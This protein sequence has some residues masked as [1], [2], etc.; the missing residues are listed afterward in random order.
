MNCCE[1]TKEFGVRFDALGFSDLDFVD[2]Q[3]ALSFAITSD[4]DCECD[5]LF[6]DYKEGD[7]HFRSIVDLVMVRICGYSLPTLIEKSLAEDMA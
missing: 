5:R 7:E 2:F 6:E 3:E 1:W 4:A